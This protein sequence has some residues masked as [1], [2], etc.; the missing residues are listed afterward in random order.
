MRWTQITGTKSESEWFDDYIRLA[1]AEPPRPLPEHQ[2]H[3]GAVTINWF[4]TEPGIAFI[5]TAGGTI[6]DRVLAESVIREQLRH[7][8]IKQA[9]FTFDWDKSD[10]LRKTATWDDIMAKATRLIQSN[11][12]SILRNGTTNVV[13]SVQGDNDTYQTEIMRQ[14]PNSRVITQW[15]CDCPWDQYAW[16]RTRQ[17]KKYEGRP[18][19]HV[20]AT[21]WKSQA[22]PIDDDVHPGNEQLGLFPQMAQPPGPQSPFAPQIPRGPNQMMAPP[23]MQ[24]QMM[25]PGIM[26]GMATGTPPTPADSGVIPPFPQAQPDPATM[27]NPA[28]VPGL[29]QPTPTNP[30]QYPGGTFSSWQFARNAA[31]QPGFIN[32]NMVSTRYEDWGE[33]QGRSAEHGAGSKARIPANSPGEVLGQDP[34]TGMVNVLFMNPALGVQEHGNFEPWGA[35]AWFFPNELVER[36]DIPRPGPAVKR[37]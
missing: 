8:G 36:P 30:V 34:A 19:S 28:S 20:L 9:E 26:P 1:L 10:P 27:P 17:W 7:H 29:K 21:F 31:Q 15:S 35:T 23:S 33:W 5:H 22:T 37:R 25:I 2:Q 16:Q 11:Q 14:D 32:G 13:G 3:L 18:C 4:E 24:Q 6:D 12:V